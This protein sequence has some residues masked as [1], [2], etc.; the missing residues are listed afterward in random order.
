MATSES[1]KWVLFMCSVISDINI[2]TPLLTGSHNFCH[3]GTCV[4]L[5]SLVWYFLLSQFFLANL[6]PQGY[7]PNGTPLLFCVVLTPQ[8]DLVATALSEYGHTVAL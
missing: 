8:A 7:I 1:S 2:F 3:F 5:M 4:S 6:N